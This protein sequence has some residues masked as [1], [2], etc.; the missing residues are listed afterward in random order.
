M[1]PPKNAKA[2]T[3]HP[4]T[5]YAEATFTQHLVDWIGSQLGLQTPATAQTGRFLARSVICADTR[6]LLTSSVR[7]I[8][9]MV[10]CPVKA[11]KLH[12]AKPR[13]EVDNVESL[14]HFQ[15]E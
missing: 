9:Q 6:V 8:H 3:W 1:T 2:R 12:S 10:N 4:T 7:P 13:L 5:T 14:S 11:P 15:V